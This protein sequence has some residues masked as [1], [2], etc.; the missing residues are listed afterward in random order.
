VVEAEVEVMQVPRLADLREELVLVMVEQGLEAEVEALLQTMVE[1]AE[2]QPRGVREEMLP[3]LQQQ[4]QPDREQT[5]VL[6]EQ[7]VRERQRQQAEADQPQL[8]ALEVLEVEV[9]FMETAI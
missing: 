6:E 8:L 9:E 5:L 1:E 7:L 3:I 2:L 4:G